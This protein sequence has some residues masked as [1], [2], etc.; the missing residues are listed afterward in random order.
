MLSDRYSRTT[1]RIYPVDMSDTTARGVFDS[2]VWD[3]TMRTLWAKNA[4]TP[5]QLLNSAESKAIPAWEIYPQPS[6]DVEKRKR[7]FR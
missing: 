7:R 6:R 2:D 1:L 3:N 4:L 5:M